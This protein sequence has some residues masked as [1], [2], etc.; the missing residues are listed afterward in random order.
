MTK[1]ESYISDSTVGMLN[2]KDNVSSTGLFGR[3]ARFAE[4]HLNKQ[5]FWNNVETKVDVWP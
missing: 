5:D 3:V 1:W 2:V 4:L